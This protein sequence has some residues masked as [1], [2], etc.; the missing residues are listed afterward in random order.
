MPVVNILKVSTLPQDIVNI[1]TIDVNT[2]F[3]PNNSP[4]EAGMNLQEALESTQ[5]QIDDLITPDIDNIEVKSPFNA[6]N[7]SITAGI[8]LQEAL[9]YTQGQLDAKLPNVLSSTGDLIIG[10][11]S[12]T[13]A[14]LL[15]NNTTT[16]KYLAEYGN[17]SI[18]TYS[19]WDQISVAD[20][21]PLS[22]SLPVVTNSSGIL[23][24]TSTIPA[25]NLGLMTGASGIAN[26]SSG[27]VPQPLIANSTQFLRGDGTWANSN[28]TTTLYSIVAAN[29]NMVAG[30]TYVCNGNGSAFTL[31]LPASPN[32]G[33]TI[34]VYDNNTTFGI[35]NVTIDR[36]GKNIGGSASNYVCS[37][38]GQR[39]Q[40]VY[41]SS[42]NNWLIVQNIQAETAVSEFT[43]QSGLAQT[44]TFTAGTTPLLFTATPIMQK[45]VG[46]VYSSG[47]FGLLIGRLWELT[48]NIPCIENNGSATRLTYQWYNVTS[49][50]TPI[51]MAGA[52]VGSANGAFNAEEGNAVAYVDLRG[53]SSPINVQL[54]CVSVD[55]VRSIGISNANADGFTTT[56]SLPTVFIRAVY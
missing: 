47:T 25:A 40:L 55:S 23:T 14:R 33:D 42:N 13:V 54:R 2:P 11:G 38:P 49:G 22:V 1:D 4:I 26:G 16:K 39:I 41:N 28:A 32:D 15:A 6:S 29:A 18:N 36:N 10:A 48:S 9:E 45:G 19:N 20:L 43:F 17:G 30:Y 34:T 37:V 27:S 7:H 21:S 24:T 5:G 44:G 56:N 50:A 3:T 52:S 53:A 46:V 35:W 8:N 51:G 12:L 31:T